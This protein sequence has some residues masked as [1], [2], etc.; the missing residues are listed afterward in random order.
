MAGI[1]DLFGMM[2]KIK[3]IQA[4]MQ[5]IQDECLQDQVDVEA[6]FCFEKCDRGPSVRIGEK[7]VTHCTVDAAWNAIQEQLGEVP[8]TQ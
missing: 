6:T 5:R 8:A 7:V 1:G 4:N 2:G 3:D